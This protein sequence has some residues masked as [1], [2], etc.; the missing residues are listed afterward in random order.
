MKTT[1][2]LVF[3]I[4]FSFGCSKEKSEADRSDS[5]LNLL[6]NNQVTLATTTYSAAIDTVVSNETE[7]AGNTNTK[8][9]TLSD[10]DTKKIQDLVALIDKET[11]KAFDE[12]ISN[13]INLWAGKPTYY[14]DPAGI[15]QTNSAEYRAYINFCA[16]K[17]KA[18]LPLQFELLAKTAAANESANFCLLWY[19]LISEILPKLPQ[20]NKYLDQSIEKYKTNK[21]SLSIDG[22]S[23]IVLGF[24]Q[25]VLQGE[26]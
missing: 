14:S 12:K 7:A 10:E 13:W 22:N 16:E 5:I 6:K 11:V 3:L 20:F 25:N 21:S 24:V 8:L 19:P 9:A 15:L 26:F 18:I 17:G 23:E 4:F 2:F 1:S